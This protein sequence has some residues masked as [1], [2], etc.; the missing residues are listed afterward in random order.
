MYC[1]SSYVF[2][3]I[4]YFIKCVYTCVNIGLLSIPQCI[5]PQPGAAIGESMHFKYKYKYG[6]PS[7]YSRRLEICACVVC[8]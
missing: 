4:V 1:F 8:G 5:S 3:F 2:N 7:I 6:L